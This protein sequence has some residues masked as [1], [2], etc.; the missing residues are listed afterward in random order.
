MQDE[1]VGIL[2]LGAAKYMSDLLT[3]SHSYTQGRLNCLHSGKQ[4][5][6]AS[7]SSRESYLDSG[8][9]LILIRVDIGTCKHL[10]EFVNL[11]AKQ[12]HTRTHLARQS[13]HKQL[14]GRWEYH[15]TEGTGQEAQGRGQ[16]GMHRI[17]CC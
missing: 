1:V 15:M 8:G 16:E 11:M 12:S 6:A 14:E 3:A 10:P 7:R 17:L 2:A 13:C 9:L 4:G 5:A